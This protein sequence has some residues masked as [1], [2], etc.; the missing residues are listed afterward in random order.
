MDICCPDVAIRDAGGNGT[1]Y[2]LVS[3]NHLMSSRFSKKLVRALLERNLATALLVA[4]NISG[5]LL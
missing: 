4:N 1:G 3:R 5:F 2:P